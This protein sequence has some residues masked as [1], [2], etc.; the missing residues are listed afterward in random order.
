MPLSNSPESE[1]CC[2][3]DLLAKYYSVPSLS[4]ICTDSKMVDEQSCIE[5]ALMSM[6]HIT[7]G[8][9][10]WEIDSRI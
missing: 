1:F 4:W 10:L 2:G 5:K 8:N 7:S 9:H 3:R 6:L